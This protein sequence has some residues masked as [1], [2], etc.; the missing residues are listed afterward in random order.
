[1]L[2]LLLCGWVFFVNK[3]N[4]PQA[5][6]PLI[7]AENTW[8]SQVVLTHVTGQLL[9]QLG[10]RVVYRPSDIYQQFLGL[11]QGLLHIQ[12]EV[13]QGTMESVVQDSLE[14][15]HL[16][17]AGFHQ[18]KTQEEWW[19]PAHVADLCP[20]LP[21]WRALNEC[22]G[23][24]SHQDDPETGVILMGPWAQ[25]ELDKVHA[26]K[27]RFKV[28]TA[29]QP[30]AIWHELA[31]AVQ[32]KQPILIYNWRPNSIEAVFEG[33]FVQFPAYHPDCVREPKWGL[34]PEA[35]YDCGNPPEGW[36]QKVVSRSMADDFPCAFALI[37]KMVLSREDFE[38]MAALIDFQ[39]YTKQDAA[40][41][42]LRR[43]PEKVR[44]WLPEPCMKVHHEQ[45]R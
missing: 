1:M 14:A 9:D 19:Y 34:N 26:L 20:G 21:D 7:L 29:L 43:H 45:S 23:L 36:I 18:V 10:Y 6:R 11:E 32:R 31:N 39:G 41:E 8:S 5:D 40:R 17:S 44:A 24:F 16:V 27:L 35:V 3:P 37:E 15:G 25:H 22:A 28:V 30:E 13:W 33:S 2:S 4:D 12:M 42:W 38:S